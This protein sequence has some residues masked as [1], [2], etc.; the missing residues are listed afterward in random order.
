ML[1]KVVVDS[2]NLIVLRFV[3]GGNG[4]GLFALLRIIQEIAVVG[5]ILDHQVNREVG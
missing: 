3:A 5:V 4:D 1:V 2:E